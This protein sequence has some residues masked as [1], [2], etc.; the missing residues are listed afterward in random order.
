MMAGNLFATQLMNSMS[1]SRKERQNLEME[2]FLRRNQSRKRVFLEMDTEQ[3]MSAAL[4][5]FALGNKK[6]R[7][8]RGPDERRDTTWWSNGYMNWN[9][10]AFKKRLRVNRTTFE[11]ILEGIKNKI[12][13]QPTLFK[14]VP[15]PPHTRLA[16]CLYRLAHGC[17]Y[18]TLGDL[19]GVAESTA[20]VVFNE[21]CKVLV[22][23][24]YDQF[25]YLPRNSNEWKQELQSFLENWEFPCVGAWDGFHVFISTKLKNYFSFK[26][27]YSVSSMG[28]IASNKRFFWAAVGAP[29]STHD[30]RL[31]RSCTLFDD[32][33]QGHVFPSASLRTSEYGEIP[34]TT[35]GDSAF[36]RYTWLM[37]PYDESTR[38]PIKRYFNKR[39]C[40]ARVVSEHAYGML[41]GR[42]R[43][44]YKKTECKLK[45]IRH[46]I[47]ACIALHNMCIDKDDPCR[48]RWR[49]AVNKLHLIRNRGNGEQTKDK[50]DQVRMQIK[51]WLWDIHQQRQLLG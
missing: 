25:V 33:Q 34:F 50:A 48:A 8:K 51:N 17:T 37:K 1:R 49:L 6:P 45:N 38:D 12:I 22:S 26:K 16:I 43:I 36:P 5:L 41:K 11:F 9:E 47:M 32:I 4:G 20:A 19:F 23:T 29:G 40:S 3:E 46:I 14:P 39:L 42:W 15:V 21:V 44:L 13:K 28:F 7:K 30:S 18:N 10:A 27:R 2:M 35:V 24:F 31:L